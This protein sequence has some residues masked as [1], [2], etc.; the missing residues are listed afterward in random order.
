LMKR[1]IIRNMEGSEKQQN[2]RLQI[3][4]TRGPPMLTSGS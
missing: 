3:R 2:A 1:A 4:I